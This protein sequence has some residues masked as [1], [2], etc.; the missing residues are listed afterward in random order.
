[1]HCASCGVAVCSS[2]KRKRE[3]A[4]LWQESR[5]LYILL[6]LLSTNREP[7][8]LSGSFV[9]RVN[10]TNS[11][12]YS[13]PTWALPN[14]LCRLLDPNSSSGRAPTYTTETQEDLGWKEYEVLDLTENKNPCFAIPSSST[15]Q[16]ALWFSL[17]NSLSFPGFYFFSMKA[18][19][20]YTCLFLIL[21]MNN[22]ELSMKCEMAPWSHQALT[23]HETN[24]ATRKNTAA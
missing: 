10:T 1:M 13:I 23:R 24:L 18:A 12:M 11:T 16:T 6:R 3:K 17:N 15:A 5:M 19:Y 14:A 20:E 7:V 22:P 2:D 9:S 4:P 8:V 21:L